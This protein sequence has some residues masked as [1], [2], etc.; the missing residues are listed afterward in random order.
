[1][2]RWDGGPFSSVRTGDRAYHAHCN[3]EDHV[4]YSSIVH[5]VHFEAGAYPRGDNHTRAGMAQAD[6]DF[7]H[8]PY[9]EE[10]KSS[11]ITVHIWW[12]VERGVKPG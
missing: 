6:G 3:D 1:M 7:D 11:G 10:G 2:G 5:L 8:E 12:K 9:N 4:Q